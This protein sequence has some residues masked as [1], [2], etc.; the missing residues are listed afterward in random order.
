MDSGNVA[1]DTRAAQG[2]NLAHLRR[3]AQGYQ[4]ALIDGRAYLTRTRIALLMLRHFCM[5][6]DSEPVFVALQEWVDHGMHG[7]VRWPACPAFA[8]WAAHQG[9]ACV[10]GCV[11]FPLDPD[12]GQA[13]AA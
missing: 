12:G 6:H 1:R 5:N 8:A 7:G 4:A 2:L 11:D 3:V 13:L 10:D 9:L